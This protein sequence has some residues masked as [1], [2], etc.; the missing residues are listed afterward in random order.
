VGKNKEVN[1]FQA[2]FASKKM[3]IF[4]DL[5]FYNQLSV[6]INGQHIGHIWSQTKFNVFNQSKAFHQTMI[7]RELWGKT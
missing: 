1:N 5:F 6:L 3:L 4:R 2:D 7:M